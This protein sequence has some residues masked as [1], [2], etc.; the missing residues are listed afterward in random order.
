[1]TRSKRLGAQLNRINSLQF[2]NRPVMG[3]TGAA[4]GDLYGFVESLWVAPHTLKGLPP[5]RRLPV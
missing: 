2:F 3:R 1:M 4:G 5:A